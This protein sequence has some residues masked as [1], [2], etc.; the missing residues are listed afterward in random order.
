MIAPPANAPRPVRATLLRLLDYLAE[1]GYGFVTPAGSTHNRVSERAAAGDEDLLR[2][3][4]GWTR[5]F[6]ERQLDPALLDLVTDAGIVQRKNGALKLTLRASTV[7]GRLYLHSAP[8]RS[9]KAVFLGPDS[10]RY[11]RFLRQSPGDSPPVA[12]ALDIGVGAGVG[13]VTLAGLHPGAHVTGSDVNPDALCLAEV[14]AAHNGVAIDLVNASGLPPS[15]ARFDVIAAN[16]PYIAGSVKR[17]YRDGGG[18]LGEGLALEWVRE[19]LPRLSPGGR[20]LLYTGSAI[21]AGRD[22][23]REELERVGSEHGCRLQYEELDPDVFGG[24]LRQESYRNVERIALVGAVLTAP[25]RRGPPGSHSEGRVGLSSSI[26][27]SPA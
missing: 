16:P 5:P 23:I 18:E 12:H 21:V 15:P 25:R 13:A 11:A 6:T 19:G 7:D 27:G 14:N 24:T 20:F 22:L 2:D 4:F 9:P 8:T 26:S 17:I 3:I 10:Y 1:R